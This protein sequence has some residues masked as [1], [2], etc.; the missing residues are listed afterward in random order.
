MNGSDA[1][2]QSHPYG[3]DDSHINRRSSF[4]MPN[5]SPK[6]S[7]PH[8]NRQ[9]SRSAPGSRR[10]SPSAIDRSGFMNR[11]DMDQLQVAF[12]RA[13]YKGSPRSS[14]RSN[15]LPRNG[16]LGIISPYGF[17]NKAVPHDS[18]DTLY[19]EGR[20]GYFGQVTGISG[21]L[22]GFFPLLSFFFLSF[23]FLRTFLVVFL[24]YGCLSFLPV[25]LHYFSFAFCFYLR[26]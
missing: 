2:F 16:D 18:N 13:Y 6:L 25:L 15:R 8:L 24:F 10:G 17:P 4:G 20:Q 26:A 3:G 14:D 1:K 19:K 5:G 11:R 9:M 12:K 22:L 23:F 7:R 21:C